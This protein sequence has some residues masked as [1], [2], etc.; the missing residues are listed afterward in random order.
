MSFRDFRCAPVLSFLCLSIFA[1]GSLI[2]QVESDKTDVSEVL[3]QSKTDVA[4]QLGAIP[5]DVKSITV[6]RS[7][8]DRGVRIYGPKIVPFLGKLFVKGTSSSNR[9]SS[10]SQI[11]YVAV[12]S[13][14]TLSYA[15]P[16]YV[17]NKP[18]PSNQVV[19]KI[20]LRSQI[21]SLESA[22]NTKVEKIR[23]T[24][25]DLAQM[26]YKSATLTRSLDRSENADEKK[27]IETEV[28][29]I[30]DETAAKKEQLAELEKD[31][32]EFKTGYFAKRREALEKGELN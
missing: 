16:D 21:R 31:L 26:A 22:L 13:I 5:A 27:L 28:Q 17:A 2:A 29:L 18:K 11:T 24:K 25:K 30:S 12:D 6:Y 8:N 15:N 23:I 1:C 20:S 14:T 4:L 3:N 7:G 32:A 9:S 19:K 10:I